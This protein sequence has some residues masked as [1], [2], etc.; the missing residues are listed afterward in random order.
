MSAGSPQQII[1][2][3]LLLRAPSAAL[4][5]AILD[6]EL[7]NQAHFAPWGPA[8][9]PSFFE[10]QAL[11]ERLSRAE[12][13]FAAGTA[14]RYWF[15]RSETPSHLIGQINLTQLSR[16][17][18]QNA[19]LGY[20]LDAQSLGQGLM[21]EALRALIQLAFD[22]PVRLHRIQAAVRPENTP[23]LA[24]LRR[25]GFELEGLSRRYLFIDGAWRDH[26]VFALLNPTWDDSEAP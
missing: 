21:N 25:L 23:S 12:Q 8:Q 4:A 26:Q 18:F 2:E 7:R 19:M 17:P 6:F 20:S 3:R 22:Q 5:P 10:P 11:A 9:A 16:G 15:S 13:D 1:T 14:L 24:V